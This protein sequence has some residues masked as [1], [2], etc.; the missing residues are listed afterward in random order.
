MGGRSAVFVS[1]AVAI[2]ISMVV[3][4]VA[5]S[6]VGGGGRSAVAAIVAEGVSGSGSGSSVH[7]S[8]CVMRAA[9]AMVV[10]LNVVMSWIRR[11]SDAGSQ[12]RCGRVA[13]PHPHPTLHPILSQLRHIHKMLLRRSFSHFL[14]CAH[15]PTAGQTAGRMDG[16]AAGRTDGQSLLELRVRN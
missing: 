5:T 8:D 12:F 10:A 3:T 7:N 9:A 14:T 11:T 1:L 13:N 15:G 16:W 6:A 4:A 2:V